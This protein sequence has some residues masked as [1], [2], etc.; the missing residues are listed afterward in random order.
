MCILGGHHESV[1]GLLLVLHSE[2]T[3][4]RAVEL[5]MVLRS[6]CKQVPYPPYYHL[7]LFGVCVC[8]VFSLIWYPVGYITNWFMPRKINYSGLQVYIFGSWEMA[9]L[10]MLRLEIYPGT[11]CFPLL[12]HTKHN[13]FGTTGLQY[14]H[15][16]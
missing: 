13:R 7:V 12:Y 5:Y 2:I 8:V 11:A 14:H 1:L 9:Q 6:A 15:W 3:S 16:A 4:G 10:Y